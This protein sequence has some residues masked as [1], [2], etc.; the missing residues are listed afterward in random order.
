M[1]PSLGS[2][3]NSKPVV[4]LVHEPSLFRLF[5]ERNL[6]KDFKLIYF[7]D[8]ES[9]IEYLDLTSKIDMLVTDLVFKNSPLGGCN[10]ARTAHQRFPASLILVFTED[11]DD[12]RVDLLKSIPNVTL[13]FKPFGAF[14][15][16]GKIKRALQRKNSQNEFST[17]V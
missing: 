11:T 17:T 14:R 15:L 6:N 10:L 2:F 3:E 12:Y 1:M 13:H 5:L 9:A 8:S 16:A 7:S 4:V